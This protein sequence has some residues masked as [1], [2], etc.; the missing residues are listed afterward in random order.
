MN[1]EG[2]KEVPTDTL[3][4]FVAG[5]YGWQSLLPLQQRAMAVELL[6]YRYIEDV[7]NGRDKA[8]RSGHMVQ[9]SCKD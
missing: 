2:Q 1:L 4:K 9:Q 8:R 5:T 3:I 6:K 7:T